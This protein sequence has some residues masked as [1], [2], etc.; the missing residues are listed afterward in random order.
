MLLNIQI[1]LSIL[2]T[3]VVLLQN[4]SV[5][6]NISSMSGDMWEVSKR[7]WEKILQNISIVLAVIF[8]LNGILLFIT[9]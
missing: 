6:L 8:T 7:G 3:I 5:T 2:L 1:I 4:K 9:L